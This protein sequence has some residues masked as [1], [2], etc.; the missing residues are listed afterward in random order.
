MSKMDGN[1]KLQKGTPATNIA[2]VLPAN[3]VLG[4]RA[5]GTKTIFAETNPAT[6]WLSE[7]ASSGGA[8]NSL[9][10]KL[11]GARRHGVN[12]KMRKRTRKP[13]PKTD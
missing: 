9:E 13:T 1:K 8:G 5:G 7:G 6:A 3:V 11:Q 2:V 4:E 10:L 12:K